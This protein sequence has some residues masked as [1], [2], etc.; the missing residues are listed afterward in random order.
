MLGREVIIIQELK[1]GFF[2]ILKPL[3]SLGIGIDQI[4]FAIKNSK[5]LTG[6]DLGMLGNVSELPSKETV[7]NFGREHPQFIGI[8]TI[9]KHIFAKEFLKNNDIESAWNVLLLN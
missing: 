6:N 4:P 8:E 1:D 9:K 7:D 2:E 5:I 3:S